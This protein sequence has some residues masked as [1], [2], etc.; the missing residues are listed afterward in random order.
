MDFELGKVNIFFGE[1]TNIDDE[2]KLSRVQVKINGYTEDL[3]EED[4]PWYFSWGGINYLPQVGDIV[5]VMIFD[6][7]ILAGFYGKTIAKRLNKDDGLDYENYLE[8]FRREVDGELVSMSYTPSKGIEF[9]NSESGM[10]VENDMITLFSSSNKITMTKSEIKIGN[11]AEQYA[12]KGDDVVKVLE[13]MCGYMK[14]ITKQFLMTS[15]T[16]PTVI[17]ACATP[18]T[19]ALGVAFGTLSAQMTLIFTSLATLQ[20]GITRSMLQSNKVKIE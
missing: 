9:I 16:W 11:N 7:N 12:L 20:A 13:Q 18:F 15:T 10:L 2:T 1:V 5:P 3:P 17:G 4:I 6:G 14:E 19:A 8:I